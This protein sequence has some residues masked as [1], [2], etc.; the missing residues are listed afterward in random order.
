MTSEGAEI[1]ELPASIYEKSGVAHAD[2][3]AVVLSTS[4][5]FVAGRHPC[6]DFKPE[7]RFV[8]DID[9]LRLY[10]RVLSN[11]EIAR[12]AMRPTAE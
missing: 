4:F 10:D 6:Y 5:H 2:F 9:E 12:L 1:C 11:D 3:S 8:G 7:H